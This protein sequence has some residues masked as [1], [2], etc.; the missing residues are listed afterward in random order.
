MGIEGPPGTTGSASGALATT[1]ATTSFSADVKSIITSGY[2]TDGD[3]GSGAI[4]VRGVAGGLGVRQS[5]DGTY[6]N[7]SKN[8]RLS[9]AFFGA[10]CDS[11]ADDTA[12]V[13]A[14]I[15]AAESISGIVDFPGWC[16]TTT[17]LQIVTG[18]IAI[19]GSGGNC[20][21]KP[22]PGASLLNGVSINTVAS[23]VFRNFGVM[24][25]G[26]A[27]VA[28]AGSGFVITASSGYGENV[29]ST[30]EDVYVYFAG[31]GFD[32]Q[33]AS[34]F[35]MRNCFVIACGDGV[36]V[37]NLNNFDSGDSSIVDCEIGGGT[38]N[39]AIKW[40]SSG[41]LR[42]R[43]IKINVARVGLL[44]ALAEGANTSGPYM[45]NCSIEGVTE[46]AIRLTK[47]SVGQL[48]NVTVVGT[49][50]FA[51]RFLDIPVAASGWLLGVTV[52]GCVLNCNQN[53]VR[54]V[55][56]NINNVMGFVVSNCTMVKAAAGGGVHQVFS[57][58]GTAE[59]GVVGPIA[60]TGA[61]EV[62]SVSAATN[63]TIIAPAGF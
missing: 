15:V 45:S 47:G 13:Q 60:L 10:K 41:G 25:P 38:M 27:P 24:Y 19:E 3:I 46:A 59:F 7:L 61:P 20:G 36:S 50:A 39:N 8:Q 35:E 28:N 31:L 56:A 29:S 44:V 43:G 55:F 4:Y 33:K 57:I 26:S 49:E 2:A 14:A 63:T 37:R 32:F 42:I 54:N 1:I 52:T 6:W 23:V 30:W 51:P 21:I 48:A 9:V 62:L 40:I 58:G 16:K 12:A 11:T 17:A 34:K 18:Y 5:L 22:T 53:T